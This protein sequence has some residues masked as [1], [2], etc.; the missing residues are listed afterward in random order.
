FVSVLAACGG[1]GSSSAAPEPEEANT[2]SVFGSDGPMAGADVFVYDLQDFI[3]NGP[4]AEDLLATPATTDPVTGLAD[5]LELS[6]DAGIGPFVVGIF[7]NETTIDLSTGEPPIVETLFTVVTSLTDDRF[8]ATPLTTAATLFVVRTNNLDGETGPPGSMSNDDFIADLDEG[9]RLAKA[10][11]GFGM[12]ADIDVFTT[13]PVLDETTTTLELQ[14][15]VAQYRG[16]NEALATVLEGLGGLVDFD[17]FFDLFQNE[18]LDDTAL[19]NAIQAFTF[20]YI[21]NRLDDPS[22]T[23]IAGLL[24]AD[25]TTLA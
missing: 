11:L 5:N 17:F 19:I 13:P 14:Q 6:L 23:S 7:A 12:D 15:Q 21:T 1:G 8:Y 25:A 4:E 2:I 16:A 3:Q 24:D 18:V 9:Q 22:I 20:A 10:Y